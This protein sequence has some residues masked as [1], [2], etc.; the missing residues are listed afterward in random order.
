MYTYDEYE[1]EQFERVPKR[2]AKKRTARRYD[3]RKVERR[4]CPQSGKAKYATEAEANKIAA[5]YAVESPK[6]VYLC[7]LCSSYH[8]YSI[9]REDS[10]DGFRRGDPYRS[11]IAGS[12]F[13]EHMDVREELGKT[14]VEALADR[15]GID[16]V[17]EDREDSVL[18]FD[19][20]KFTI[21]INEQTGRSKRVTIACGISLTEVS[22][23]HEPETS[24]YERSGIS[25]HVRAFARGILADPTLL[26]T[27]YNH[28]PASK[29][30]LMNRFDVTERVASTMLNQFPAERQPMMG[31]RAPRGTPSPSSKSTTEI[32]SVQ[33]RS[34]PR[35]PPSTW[36]G[37][38]REAGSPWSSTAER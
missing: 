24:I 37:R 5:V 23:Q 25:V 10:D 32:S 12:E 33:I 7:P 4:R 26:E 29:R 3:N 6:G 14:D 31:A 15:L 27:L 2:K 9:R 18:R 8:L 21:V 28:N 20:E 19:G 35:Q 11:A 22:A 1:D 16:V 36:P 17:V 34:W 13:T 38:P 30:L